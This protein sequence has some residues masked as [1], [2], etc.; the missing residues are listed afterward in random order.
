MQLNICCVVQVCMWW[1]ATNCYNLEMYVAS[2]AG[3]FRRT[4]KLLASDRSGAILW[5]V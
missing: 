3:T 1:G 2:I 5:Q 4:F